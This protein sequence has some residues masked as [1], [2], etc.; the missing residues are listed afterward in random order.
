MPPDTR[1]HL[2]ISPLHPRYRPAGFPLPPKRLIL[3]RYAPRRAA[4]PR[5]P[6]TIRRRKQPMRLRT[7][8]ATAAATAI[9]AI[10]LPAAQ[11][12]PGNAVVL[13]DSL[14]ANPTVYDFAAGKANLPLPDA[15]ISKAGCGT[16]FRF[17][18][19]YGAAAGRHVDDYTCAGASYRT[20]GMRIAEQIQRA[21]DNGDLNGST[22]EVVMLAGAN[23]T[24]PYV[25]NDHMPVPEVRENLR[26]AVREA[27]HQ[28]KAAAPNA[29]V[30]VVG[31]PT[32]SAPDGTVCVFNLA[33]N[34]PGAPTPGVNIREIEDALQGGVA[35]AARD[36]G[37][38]FVDSKRVTGGHG[39]CAADPWVAGIVSMNA[40]PHNLILHM[41]DA[42]LDAVGGNAA[43][44]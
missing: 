19:A 21:R 16:D 43:R 20:G 37:A 39:T 35:D 5:R 12:A 42:G 14:A 44:G 33:P 31:Y 29:V 22:R 26:A 32:V 4:A 41:T 27:I 17:S 1:R 25:L 36:A 38:R 18:G 2:V 30:K 28:A 15:R 40:G 7:V 11:A 24:Y 13:G 6:R 34:A 8:L 3:Y 23:D 10:S 9:A